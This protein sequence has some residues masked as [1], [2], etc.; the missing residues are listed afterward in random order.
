MAKAIVLPPDPAPEP[1]LEPPAATPEERRWVE[2]HPRNL[3]GDARALT[4]LGPMRSRDLWKL[5]L[6]FL[7]RRYVASFRE[8][9]ARP[10]RALSFIHFARWTLIEGLPGA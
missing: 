7:A 10:L 1:L 8:A 4:V 2:A 9:K 6:G 3:D 5:K